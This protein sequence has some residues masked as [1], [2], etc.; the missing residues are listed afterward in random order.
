MSSEKVNHWKPTFLLWLSIP[1]VSVVIDI[2]LYE[3]YWLV[4]TPFLLAILNDDFS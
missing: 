3:L 1:T 4:Y 2:S